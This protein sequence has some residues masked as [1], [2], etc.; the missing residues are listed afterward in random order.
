MRHKD[1]VLEET[2]KSHLL[3]MLQILGDAVFD[4]RSAFSANGCF[5]NK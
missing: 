5:T 1:K 2:W 3:L 4:Y